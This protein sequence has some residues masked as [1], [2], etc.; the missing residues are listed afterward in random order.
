MGMLGKLMF[1]KKEGEK[2]AKKIPSFAPKVGAKKSAEN[3]IRDLINL[4]EVRNLEEVEGATKKIEN[5]AAKELKKKLR[6]LAKKV[7]RI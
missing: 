3:A 1:W 6:S 4:V 5:S 2:P 7:G